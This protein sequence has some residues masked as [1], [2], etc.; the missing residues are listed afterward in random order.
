MFK[1]VEGC[2]RVNVVS[3]AKLLDIPK[4]VKFTCVDD[5]D[6][7]A[8]ESHVTVDGIVEIFSRIAH[9]FTGSPAQTFR[10]SFYIQLFGSVRQ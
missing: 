3:S 6:Q 1:S 10:G 2:S 7:Q 5:V 8:V 9:R 4:S